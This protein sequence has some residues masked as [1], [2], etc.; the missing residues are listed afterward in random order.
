M[1][2]GGMPWEPILQI[3]RTDDASTEG[4]WEEVDEVEEEE[5]E[6]E[7][8]NSNSRNPM[9]RERHTDCARKKETLLFDNATLILV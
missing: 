3:A 6:E 2:H 5:E 1:P 8:D 7:Y 4:E 9:K